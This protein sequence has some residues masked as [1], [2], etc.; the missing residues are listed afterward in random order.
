M[1]SRVIVLF[2]GT[3]TERRVSVASACNVAAAIDRPILLFIAPSGAVHRVTREEL[4]SHEQPFERD[5]VPSSPAAFSGLEAALDAI[6]EQ[7]VLFLALHGGEGENGVLQRTLEARGL[8]FTGSGSVASAA[9]FDKLCAKRTVASVGVRVA[10]SQ[11]VSGSEPELRDA[12][13]RLFERQGRLVI[14]PVADGSSM[15]LHHLSGPDQLDEVAAAVARAG[16]PYLAE[17]FVAGTELTIGVM[18]STDAP[19]PLPVSEIRVEPGR[20]FD[21]AGKYLGRGTLE[22]TPASV[23]AEVA[24]EA[25]RVAV[26]AH[27]ALGCEGYTRT[28]VIANDDGI[29]YL[30]TNTLPGLTSASFV[31]QQ[32]R[33]MGK[34]LRWFVAE[35][36][37]AAIARRDRLAPVTR[38][39]GPVVAL[40]AAARMT[41]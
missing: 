23:P 32:L 2:G 38:G 9:A 10:E 36:V 15:G 18:D 5:L 40:E 4:A 7:D 31:P 39:V 37:R 8:A 6:A 20:A 30:E 1:P 14:K 16:V 3:S 12:L 11:V 21:F 35:Q 13:A 26:A 33:A 19:V 34:D 27:R 17:S 25:Q 28:D 24:L 29:V 22:L 41:F